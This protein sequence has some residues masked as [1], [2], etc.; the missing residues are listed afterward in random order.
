ML[1]DGKDAVVMAL[2]T[3]ANREM[4]HRD[5]QCAAD[6]KQME[7]F[8]RFP[9]EFKIFGTTSWD[10]KGK[11]YYYATEDEDKLYAYMQQKQFSGVYF[12]PISSYMHYTKVFS[13]KKEEFLYNTK[14]MLLKKMKQYYEP[15]YFSLMQSFFEESPNNESDPILEQ[16]R[17]KIEGYFDDAALQIFQGL[18]ELAYESK[19]IKQSGYNQFK[20]WHDNV[21]H[22]MEE[23][24]IGDGIFERTFY[25]FA[26]Y[27]NMGMV[28]TFIDARKQS[29]VHKRDTLLLNGMMVG[30]ILQKKYYFKELSQINFMKEQ[31]RQW[32]IAVQNEQYFQSIRQIKSQPGVITRSDMERVKNS[33]VKNQEAY[34]AVCY[35][36]V[37]WNKR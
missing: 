15:E 18:L 7:E 4:L 31:Y 29:V 33:L 21:R 35:Y 1:K 8:G 26:Y 28:K 14:Y 22:Q 36:D 37:R 13:E 11:I 6:V 27:T 10:E 5:A 25:G 12:T 2:L 3:M 16:N 32:L 9:T 20:E 17:E 23:E 30:S 24:P 19:T 34:K